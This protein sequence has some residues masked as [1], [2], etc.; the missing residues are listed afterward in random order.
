MAAVSCR[1]DCQREGVIA[2]RELILGFLAYV[3]LPQSEF[4]VNQELL[5]H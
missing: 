3:R 1:L 5:S 4:D 2:K